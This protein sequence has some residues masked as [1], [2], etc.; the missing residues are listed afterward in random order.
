MKAGRHHGQHVLDIH[1]DRLEIAVYAASQGVA[2]HAEPLPSGIGESMFHDHADAADVPVHLLV[3]FRERMELG[4]FLRRED[5]VESHES[6]VSPAQRVLSVLHLSESHLFYDRTVVFLSF[7]RFSQDENTPCLVGDDAVFCRVRFLL[8]RIVLLLDLVFLRPLY[9][10]LASVHEVVFYARKLLDEFFDAPYLPLREGPLVS[11]R[12]FEQGKIPH[13][14]IVCPS[15]AGSVPKETHELES[16]VVPRVHEYEEEL[17]FGSGEHPFASCPDGPAG[18]FSWIFQ[19]PRIL[20]LV[21]FLVFHKECLNRSRESGKELF[22]MGKG[23][24]RES[25]KDGRAFLCLVKI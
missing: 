3:F 12:L 23:N 14:P 13:Y 5:I 15:L 18:R 4:R 10:S 17:R 20:L 11:E 2:Y 25:P 21:A 8:S 22:E 6:S 24:A 1:P 19:I 9:P 16:E 7:H